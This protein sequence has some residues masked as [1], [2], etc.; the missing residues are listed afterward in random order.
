MVGWGEGGVHAEAAA[1]DV[2]EDG[3]FSGRVDYSGQEDPSGDGWVG[4][5]DGVF[6][7]DAGGGVVERGNG[8]Y[9]GSVELHCAVFVDAEEAEL[10]GYLRVLR[11]GHCWSSKNVCCRSKCDRERER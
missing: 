6:G 7:A 2:E 9:G 1:V 5:N 8:L 11:G 10:V 4:G 3:K